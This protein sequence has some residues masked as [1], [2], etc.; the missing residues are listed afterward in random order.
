M[1]K[2][3]TM[4]LL[5]AAGSMA[6]AKLPP[7]SDEAKAKADEAKAKADH[8]AKVDAY[9][10]C[11]AQDRTAAHYLRTA[12]D[13]KPVATAP[14]ADPGAFQPPKP[15]EAAAAHSPAATAVAPPADKKA[16]AAQA[17]AKK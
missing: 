1:K 2:T 17:A 12:K 16:D 13:A 6:M 11:L 15:L 10:L 7:L 8:T 9:K 3:L 4:I 14:C 5:A